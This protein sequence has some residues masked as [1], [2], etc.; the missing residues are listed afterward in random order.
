MMSWLQEILDISHGLQPQ[1][2][3]KGFPHHGG[4]IAN[5]YYSIVES[6]EEHKS[7]GSTYMRMETAL[8]VGGPTIPQ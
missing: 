3:F 7:V 2:H 5:S 6:V 1:W 8:D 4:I